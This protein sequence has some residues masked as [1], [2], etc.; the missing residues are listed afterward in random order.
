MTLRPMMAA[1]A[2]LLALALGGPVLAQNDEGGAG[3]YS[4]ET[5]QQFVEAHSGVLAI[6]DEYTQRL[7]EA[8]D[9]EQ[10]MALQEEANERMV[11]AVTDT[12]LSVEEYGEIA[13]AASGDTE[14][15]ER[16]QDMME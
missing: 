16:I 6:R 11:N 9:R 5:L 2:L 3:G 10:A 13:R 15:S 14:L 7:Q 12:G 8:D 1:L 4:E